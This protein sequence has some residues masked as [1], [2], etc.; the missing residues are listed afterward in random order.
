MELK[1]I[2]NEMREAV[3]SGELND[4][5]TTYIPDLVPDNFKALKAIAKMHSINLIANAFSEYEDGVEPDYMILELFVKRL[6]YKSNNVKRVVEI[7]F[8]YFDCCH[9]SVKIENWNLNEQPDWS[10]VRIRVDGHYHS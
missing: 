5:L 1:E 6:D 3:K 9:E 4:F 8:A 7:I 2:E 10:Y